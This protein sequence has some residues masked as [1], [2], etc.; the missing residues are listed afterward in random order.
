VSARLQNFAGLQPTRLHSEKIDDFY[1]DF[2]GK[3]RNVSQREGHA[4]LKCNFF[5]QNIVQKLV[6]EFETLK[7]SIKAEHHHING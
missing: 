3:Q 4:K 1:Q 5:N 6:L 2:H 7:K